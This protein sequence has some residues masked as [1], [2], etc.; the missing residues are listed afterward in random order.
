MRR[1][2]THMVICGAMIAAAL[3]LGVLTG[4]WSALAPAAACA[5]MMYVMMQMMGGTHDHSEKR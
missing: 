2:G 3:G 4:R 5:V 1:H